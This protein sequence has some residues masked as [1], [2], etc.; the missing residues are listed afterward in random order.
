M[1]LLIDIP[2]DIYLMCL[3]C[4]GDADIIESAIA[5]GVPVLDDNTDIESEK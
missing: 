5:Q 2:K 1:K 3:A 4:Q